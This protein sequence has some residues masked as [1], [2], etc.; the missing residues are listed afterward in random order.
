MTSEITDKDK[1]KGW[2]LYDAECP[3]CVRLARRL[4]GVLRRRHFELVPLQAPWARAK[5]G[6]TPPQLL[7]EMRFLRA[8]G[9]VFGGADAL[10]EISRHI[11][12]AWPLRPAGRLPA[13]RKLLRSG[14]RW[15]ARNRAC[16]RG[17]CE[18]IPGRG[19]PKQTNRRPE[20][21]IAFL[22]MP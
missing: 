21:K 12:W 4:Q 22:E 17:A 9:A 3:V 16:A 14:Y 15:I 5:L 13:V 8:D 7:A 19:G 18:R 11:W 10:L 6:L 20:R 2:V 1:V